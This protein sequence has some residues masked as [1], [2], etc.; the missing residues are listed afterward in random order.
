MKRKDFP[1]LPRW[2]CLPVCFN[3]QS[4][5]IYSALCQ[6]KSMAVWNSTWE[7]GSPL[8]PRQLHS[9]LWGRD[10]V[11]KLPYPGSLMYLERLS[12]WQQPLRRYFKQ[13]YGASKSEFEDSTIFD[14]RKISYFWR[15]WLSSSKSSG[16]DR[17]LKQVSI[18]FLRCWLGCF[19]V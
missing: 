2:F 17:V 3:Q 12:L 16:K 18:G 15:L 11:L 14:F 5:I 7:Q 4:L 8:F 1:P 6:R 9:L 10:A 19:F 13:N